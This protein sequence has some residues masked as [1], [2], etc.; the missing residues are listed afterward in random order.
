MGFFFMLP[1]FVSSQ[2]LIKEDS[3]EALYRTGRY[4]KKNELSILKELAVNHRD[5]EKRLAYSELLI[6]AAQTADSL[7][8]L[9]QGYLEK[10]TALRLKGDL[11]RS[12]ESYFEAQRVAEEMQKES[13]LGTVYIAIADVYAVMGN[14]SNAVKFHHR[15]IDKLRQEGDSVNIASALLNAGDEYTNNNELDTALAY[16]IEAEAIFKKIDSPIGQ[17]YSLGNLGII[18]AKLGLDLKAEYHLNQAILLLEE[19]QDYYPIAIYLTFMSD[20]YVEKDQPETA[21]NYALRSLA[22]SKKHGMKK[23]VSDA[24]L[25]LSELYESA[26][27]PETAFNYFKDHIAYKDS[28][29]NIV[30]VQQMADLR[31][32]FEVSKKQVEVDLLNQQRKNQQIIVIGIVIALVLISLLAFGLYRRYRFIKETNQIIEQ[33]RSRSENLLLNIL[34]EGTANELKQAGKVSAKR[35]ESVTVLFTDFIGFTQYAE[36]LSPEQL[37]KRVDFYFSKFDAIVEKYGL[38][39]IKTIGDAYMCAGGLPIA[40]RDHASRMIRAAM[41]IVAFVEEEKATSSGSDT[42][43]IR[44][45]VNTGPVVAGV[46]GTKKFAYDIWGDTVNIAARME[47]SSEAGRVNIS[48]YT[49]ELIKGEFDCQY[50]GE[51]E[52][53][54]KGKMKMYFVES[55]KSLES[56]LSS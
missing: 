1:F 40:S 26:G 42:F 55:T 30:S 12:L 31:T 32:D 35:F 3:L 50:R 7:D 17:A 6:T 43:N 53:K 39:K 34:P 27:D 14:H 21:L 48:E 16:T 20:I 5:I 2:D 52:V 15:A 49:Y 9:F 25:K 8:Y 24:N 10:G 56:Q 33:E 37:V 47:S 36:N 22:L 13:R 46:V 38:E 23:E 29:N 54:N 28:V 44:I 11:T 18:Y 4:E 41:E 45:G 19:V 51:V